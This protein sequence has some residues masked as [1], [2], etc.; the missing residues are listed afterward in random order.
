[1]PVWFLLSFFVVRVMF[2]KLSKLNIKG[3]KL[4]GVAIM[5]LMIPYLLHFASFRYPYYIANTLMGL[6]GFILGYSYKNEG[7]NRVIMAVALAIY[8]FAFIFCPSTVDI[9]TNTLWRGDFLVWA[10]WSVCGCISFIV[11]FSRCEW[12]TSAMQKLGICYIGRESMLLL[13]LHWPILEIAKFLI[14][15]NIIQIPQEYLLMF[16]CGAVV[17]F[18]PLLMYLFKKTKLNWIFN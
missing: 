16:N 11:L 8:A 3:T 5:A 2:W 12:L 15:E 1:M 13:C 14:G 18:C 10:L 6:F 4:F 9:R 7:N 17:I